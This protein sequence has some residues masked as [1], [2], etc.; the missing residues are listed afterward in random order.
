MGAV[1]KPLFDFDSIVDINLSILHMMRDCYSN[2]DYVYDN[3]HK[4]DDYFMRCELLLSKTKNPLHIFFKPGNVDSIDNLYESMLVD[5]QL[6]R[7]YTPT[8]ILT[9]LRIYQEADYISPAIL[10]KNTQEEHH[11]RQMSKEYHTEYKTIMIP[12]NHKININNT[13]DAYYTSDIYNLDYRL[14]NPEGIQFKISKFKYN[15]E[16]KAGGV[17]LP[18]ISESIKYADTNRF[19]FIEPYSDFMLPLEQ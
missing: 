13:F 9:M 4:V 15:M 10:C 8:S 12:E 1:L 2:P 6:A 3:I 7:F 16:P 19:S 18:L 17:S 11:I 14:D 5:P